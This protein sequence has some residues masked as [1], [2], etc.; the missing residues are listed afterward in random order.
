MC[1]M[2]QSYKIRRLLQQ[3]GV[4]RIK[5]FFF[6]RLCCAACGTLVPQPG[7]EPRPMAVKA[8]S[9]NQWTA[10]EFPGIKFYQ[11]QWVKREAIIGRDIRTRANWC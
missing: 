1:K 2:N 9:P 8:P 5:V 3:C 11:R 7:I 6:F 4:I 10:R